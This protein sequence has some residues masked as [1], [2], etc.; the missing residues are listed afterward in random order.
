MSKIKNKNKG[1]SL[2]EQFMC[3]TICSYLLLDLWIKFL[4]NNVYRCSL[5]SRMDRNKNEENWPISSGGDR[6]TVK[7]ELSYRQTYGKY[8]TL[9]N[10]FSFYPR[11][12]K[13]GLYKWQ[14]RNRFMF[15]FHA[16]RNLFIF[17]LH[18]LSIGCKHFLYSIM[19]YLLDLRKLISNI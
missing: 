5:I 1:I 13:F 9:L 17:L 4:A 3:N 7:K 2:R 19:H 8:N 15:L 12:L 14:F 16:L 11:I 6:C 10:V 18:V